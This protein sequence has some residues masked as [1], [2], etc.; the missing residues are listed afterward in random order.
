MWGR[1]YSLNCWA[2]WFTSILV[3]TSVSK[4]VKIAV[5]DKPIKKFHKTLISTNKLGMVVCTHHPCVGS[6]DLR[7]MS[8]PSPMESTA[9]L[10]PEKELQTCIPA[11]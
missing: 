9:F 11:S 1:M 4:I 3:D 5:L 6:G 10:H 8:I 2:Q 7:Q